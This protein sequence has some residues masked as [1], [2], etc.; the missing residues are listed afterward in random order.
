MS[1]IVFFLI[2]SHLS[3][4][5]SSFPVGSRSLL[6]VMDSKPSISSDLPDAAVDLNATNFDAVLRLT[7]APHAIV[8][9][10]A[11]WCPACRNYKPHYEKVAR[12]FSGADAAHPGIL[13]MAR[14]DCALRINTKLCDKFS[15]SRYPMLLWG[16]T[17]KFVSGVGWAPNQEKSEI[18]A[19]EDGRTADRLLNWINRRMESSFRLDDEKY[20]NEHLKSNASDPGQIMRA[21]YDVEEATAFA[22]EIIL[23]HKMIKSET[24]DSFIRFLQLLVAHHPSRRCRRGSA[25]ILVNFDDLCPSYKWSTNEQEAVVGNLKGVLGNFQICGKEVPR[26]YWMF[27]RG[28]KNGTRG[29]SCGLWVLL[30]SLSVRIEDGESHMAFT[31]I[32]DYVHNF[33][34]CEECQKHFYEMCSSVSAPFNKSRDFALWLWSA[35]NNVSE[36]LMKEEASLGTGDP[37]FPKII[38]PPRQLC[39][40]CYLSDNDRR[41][42]INWDQNEVF[43]FLVNYYGK[44]LVSLYKEKGQFLDGYKDNVNAEELVAATNAIVVPLGAALAIAFASCAFGALACFWR[45]HQKNRKPRRSWN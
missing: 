30:H 45:S 32:C 26:G 13:L 10:F 41:N 43:K 27:C 38:W 24:R 19:I 37:N 6:R 33:F 16:P 29:F 21:V 9:F 15:V 1:P 22:F 18:H 40:S 11:N 4:E 35:H 12:L 7:P 28:S 23:D 17:A 34:V 20:E 25:E 8:E 31:A 44:M 3:F 14:V 2:L 42:R 5:A 36:R 39:S